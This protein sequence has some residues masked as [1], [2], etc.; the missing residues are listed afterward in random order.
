MEEGRGREEGGPK[1]GRRWE[2]GRLGLGI[3]GPNSLSSELPT[4]TEKCQGMPPKTPDPNDTQHERKEKKKFNFFSK[5]WVSHST[6]LKMNSTS[7]S[8]A[9]IGTTKERS[10]KTKTHPLRKARGTSAASA[11]QVPKW[12]RAQTN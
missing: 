3:N 4:P 10:V 8:N 1:G 5:N 9:S 7:N 2:G 12:P 6:P 11:P